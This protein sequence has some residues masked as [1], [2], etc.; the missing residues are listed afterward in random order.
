[1][2]KSFTP[3][4]PPKLKFIELFEA[5]SHT[6]GLVLLW[7]DWDIYALVPEETKAVLIRIYNGSGTE[8]TV[9]VRN[10]DSALDRKWTQQSLAFTDIWTQYWE[11]GVIEIYSSDDTNVTFGVMG[12]LM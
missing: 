3:P 12:Y 1:M 7:E 11:G 6:V 10:H 2:P 9:G 4:P 8:E 5:P